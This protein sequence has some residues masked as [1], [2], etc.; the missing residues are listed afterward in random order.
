[1]W[2]RVFVW[3]PHVNGTQLSLLLW[4][5]RTALEFPSFPLLPFFYYQRQQRWKITGVPSQLPFVT[6]TKSFTLVLIL[7]KLSLSRG[8]T[9]SSFLAQSFLW[10]YFLWSDLVGWCTEVLFSANQSQ[11]KVSYQKHIWWSL[12][13]PSK[14]F[15]DLRCYSG[16]ARCIYGC[17][18]SRGLL[19]WIKGNII[20]LVDS[21]WFFP[22]H[23]SIHCCLIFVA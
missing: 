22:I 20:S 5:E 13:P 14:M 8:V 4:K 6:L 16:P 23:F 11:H 9:A 3:D 2:G 1:M 18:E 7:Q 12:L 15:T 10:N 19:L 17:G 21:A